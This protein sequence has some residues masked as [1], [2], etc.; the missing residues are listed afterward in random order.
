[1]LRSRQHRLLLAFYLGIAFAVAI[2]FKKSDEAPDAATLRETLNLGPMRS[3]MVM[4]IL[5]VVGIRIV[6]SLPIDMKANWIFRTTPTPPQPQGMIARRRALYT[7]SVI[8]VCLGSAALLFSIW[9]W[10]AAVRHL[11]V[12]ALL[13]VVM[14]ELCLHGIQKLPFTCSYLPGKANL[15]VALQLSGMLLL[16]WVVKT[17]QLERDSFDNAAGYATIV[18]LLAVVAICTRW[19]AARLAR[20]EQGALQFEDAME[21]A[22]FALDLHR[23]GV[24]PIAPV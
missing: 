3:T 11:V 10:Q 13:G 24:T 18:G 20:S 1:M 7:L 12:L 19:S 21:P 8:P 9:P 22:V 4:M 15:N 17:A 23:D 16:P 14:A 6:F 2:L 5:C